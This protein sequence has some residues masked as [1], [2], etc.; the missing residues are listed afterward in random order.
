MIVMK[1]QVSSNDW[2]LHNSKVLYPEN[3]KCEEI[4]LLII[5]SFVA[6]GYKLTPQHLQ[7]DRKNG[8]LST[9][10]YFMKLGI[11]DSKSLEYPDNCLNCGCRN[12]VR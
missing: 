8:L 2:L 5:A 9:F 6:K 7:D 3:T 10:V 4:T 11:E 12:Q 1:V